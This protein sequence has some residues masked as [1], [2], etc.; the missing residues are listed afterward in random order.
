MIR[1]AFAM[2]GGGGGQTSANPIVSFVPF[3]LIILIFYFLL[4][5]PQMKKQKEHQ[6]MIGSIRRGDKVITS[7]GIH[8]TVTNVKDDVFV[9][10]ISKE[11]EIE[12]SKSAVAGLKERSREEG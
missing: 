8:G 11:T 1:E 12:V 9:V 3:L 2:A 7:G 10:K 5:R 6:R 4:I